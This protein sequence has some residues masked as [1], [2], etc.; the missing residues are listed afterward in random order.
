[1]KRVIA[2]SIFATAVLVLVSA[3]TCFA[4]GPHVFI[5]GNFW[6]GPN[7]WW[8]APYYYPGPPVIVQQPP[9]YEAPV[10]QPPQVA[11]WYYCPNPQGYYPYVQLCP[12]GWLQV[13]P[14]AVPSGR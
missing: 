1:M 7:P 14:P 6:L 10:P 2:S 13:V 8:W 5:E 11:Y 4:R 9:A 3:P 12:A